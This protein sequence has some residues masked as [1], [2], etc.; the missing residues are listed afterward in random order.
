MNLNNLFDLSCRKPKPVLRISN[1][2]MWVLVYL[3]SCNIVKSVN[4]EII[5]D[6][7]DSIVLI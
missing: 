7:S 3:A 2:E 6:L 1:K 4:E 5:F